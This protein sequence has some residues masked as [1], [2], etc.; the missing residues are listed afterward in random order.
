MIDHVI[1]C[2]PGDAPVPD[3]ESDCPDRDQHTPMPTGYV[4]AG[5]WA[6]QMLARGAVQRRC[7]TCGLWAVWTA[8]MRPMP[9]EGR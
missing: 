2:D 6:G 9:E 1:L 8:P 5:V 3:V 4:A 7:P